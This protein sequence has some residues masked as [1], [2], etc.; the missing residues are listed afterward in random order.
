[1]KTDWTQESL[2]NQDDQPLLNILKKFETENARIEQI[3]A[4]EQLYQSI[5]KKRSGRIFLGSLSGVQLS[6]RIERLFETMQ[7]GWVDPWPV[8]EAVE[9]FDGLVAR[10]VAKRLTLFI[11][12]LFTIIP[13]VGS[14]VLLAQQNRH[15]IEQN[16]IEETFEFKQI[17]K[18]LLEI[19]NGVSR[20][21]VV[22]DGEQRI[23]L[24]PSYHKRIREEAFGSYIAI[25]KQRWE[26]HDIN[27]LPPNR[28]VDLR[29][30]NLSG[31][32][33]GGALGLVE[34]ESRDDLTRVFLANADLE[35]TKFLN[36]KLTGTVFKN[37]NATGI[38]ISSP[39]ASHA[40]FSH[41]NAQ[42]AAFYSDPKTSTPLD[43]TQARFD[44]ANLKN[45]VFDQAMLIN[46]NFTG[47]QLEGAQILGGLIGECD[48]TQADIG[49]GLAIF[50]TP[51]HKTLF[52]VGQLKRV[53]LPPFC[54]AEETGDPNIL[55]IMT[56]PEKYNAWWSAMSEELDAA[57]EQ[58]LQEVEAKN[59]QIDEAVGNTPN[60]SAP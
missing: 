8:D 7:K 1:M 10:M 40:D 54:Y 46:V 29:G 3:Q 15:L 49:E 5:I 34:G 42:G 30:C 23:E 56:D 35:N 31:L 38:L 21:M 19:I 39:D 47:T 55:R 59:Q 32:A 53:S 16:R 26:T 48:F 4:R 12:A 43:L 28:Y 22:V 14:L 17:R 27:A 20:Q 60:T 36:S 52:T 57:V 9:V 13:A 11:V 24:L 18:G 6:K 51:I 37:A 41:I 45:A 25:D 58:E 2:N 50:E 33:L 44:Q